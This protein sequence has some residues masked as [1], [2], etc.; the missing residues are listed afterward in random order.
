MTEAEK[1]ELDGLYIT[2]DTLLPSSDEWDKA[3]ERFC[4]LT[5]KRDQEFF[6]DN[7][8]HLEDFFNKHIKGKEFSE[9]APED[10]DYYS[11]Y[12]KD[13]Y[14]YRPKGIDFVGQMCK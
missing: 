5:A 12:H 2:L 11:D 9:I 1:R 7:I 3:Y 14:G 8:E 10:W 13:V 6:E 4:E